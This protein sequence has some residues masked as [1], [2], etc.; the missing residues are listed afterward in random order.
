MTAPRFHQCLSSIKLFITYIVG[1]RIWG[2]AVGKLGAMGRELFGA[3]FQFATHGAWEGHFLCWAYHGTS[4]L[5]AC[6]G[7]L[8]W[9][10]VQA[11]PAGFSRGMQMDTEMAM[12]FEAGVAPVCD[13]ATGGCW[14]GLARP[15][16]PS[17]R[18]TPPATMPPSVLVR[19]AA[20]VEVTGAGRRRS[21]GKMSASGTISA[22]EKGLRQDRCIGWEGLY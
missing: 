20:D 18:L 11:Y 13:N 7:V 14:A 10:Y 19:R 5:G 21:P 9:L 15:L 3:T 1:T 16:I 8:V 2:G 6:V 4:V 22:C 17:F 12:R